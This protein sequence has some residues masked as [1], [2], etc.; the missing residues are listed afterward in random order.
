MQTLKSEG[1][2]SLEATM[3]QGCATPTTEHS[4]SAQK[5]AALENRTSRQRRRAAWGWEGSGWRF[6]AGHGGRV[7]HKGIPS[8]PGAARHSDFQSRGCWDRHCLPH[9]R[10]GWGQ[11]ALLLL[12]KAS[13]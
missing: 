7:F 6:S 13:I 9:A 4:P 10:R 2:Y 11:F 1:N 8:S 12:P 5:Y 3:A